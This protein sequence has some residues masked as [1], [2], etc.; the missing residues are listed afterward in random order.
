MIS[1]ASSLPTAAKILAGKFRDIISRGCKSCQATNMLSPPRS[2]A[3]NITVSC[4]RP[5][6]VKQTL[7]SPIMLRPWP[8]KLTMPI[9]GRKITKL[10]CLATVSHTTDCV[11]PVSG[12]HLTSISESTF[13][14]GASHKRRG[15]VGQ[16]LWP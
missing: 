12:Q 15:G 3:I 11:A 8:L 1:D 2:D 10:A 5:L 6:N 7:D 16:E 9:L 4:L 14:A 13:P